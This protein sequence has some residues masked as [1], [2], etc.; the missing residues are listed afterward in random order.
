MPA[1]LL[2]ERFAICSRGVFFALADWQ[3]DTASK[4]SSV[5]RSGLQDF[6]GDLIA[7]TAS[8][9]CAVRERERRFVPFPIPRTRSHHSEPQE[10]R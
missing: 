3:R 5:Q 7:M 4:R 8:A 10:A 1:R 2:A 6:A 9:L